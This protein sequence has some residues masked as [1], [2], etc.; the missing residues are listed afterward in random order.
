[1]NVEFTETGAGIFFCG[2]SYFNHFLKSL[3]VKSFVQI[4]EERP[5]P[6]EETLREHSG[7]SGFRG[8]RRRRSEVS[9][10]QSAKV[11]R[12]IL[13]LEHEVRALRVQLREVLGCI[14]IEDFNAKRRMTGATLPNAVLLRMVE[15][16][17][18]PQEWFESDVEERFWI[19]R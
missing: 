7:K 2:S 8:V 3:V 6:K 18:P 11:S 9:L 14:D 17:S 5:A 19:T 1:M 15:E 16:N 13:E 12:R 4:S 10:E